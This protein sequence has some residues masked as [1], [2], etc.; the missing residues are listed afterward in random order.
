MA[1][2]AS[3]RNRKPVEAV[4]LK[5]T[6]NDLKKITAGGSSFGGDTWQ[7]IHWG[8]I[9]VGLEPVQSRASAMAKKRAK[10]TTK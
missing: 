8:R 3:A 6:L 9:A 7:Q 4:T 5:L 2:K 1:K 10:K